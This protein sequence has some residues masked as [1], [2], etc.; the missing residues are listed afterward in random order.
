MHIYVYYSLLPNVIYR[1]V[2]VTNPVL[3]VILGFYIQLTQHFLFIFS[4]RRFFSKP[5]LCFLLAFLFAAILHQSSY[6]SSLFSGFLTPSVLKTT[7]I[8]FLF[9]YTALFSK[10]SI[11]SLVFES[12]LF[13]CRLPSVVCFFFTFASLKGSCLLSSNATFFLIF[14]FFYIYLPEFFLL[15]LNKFYIKI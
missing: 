3:A 6:F 10:F 11:Y 2:S 14:S 12:Y 9:S 13:S 5:L 1:A 4:V 8:L 15:D 7:L